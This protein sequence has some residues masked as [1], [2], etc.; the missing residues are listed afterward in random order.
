MLNGQ[1]DLKSDEKRVLTVVGQIGETRKQ[2][3][4]VINCKY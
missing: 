3:L 1:D 4:R 2:E